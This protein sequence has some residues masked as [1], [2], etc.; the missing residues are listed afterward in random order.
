M[1]I[2]TDMCDAVFAEVAHTMHINTCTV[3][4]SEI[5]QFGFVLGDLHYVITAYGKT[6]SRPHML[7]VCEDGSDYDE[8]TS[9]A[10]EIYGFLKLYEMAESYLK[11][12]LIS[13]RVSP[14]V[15]CCDRSDRHTT[16]EDHIMNVLER[17]V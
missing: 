15:G 6:G 10:Y 4:F 13:I 2:P 5:D 17:C 14:A 11:P 12:G 1:H 16:D 9:N 8:T 3:D 7:I